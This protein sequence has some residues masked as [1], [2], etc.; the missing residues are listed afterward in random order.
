MF[1][2]KLRSVRGVVAAGLVL[3]LAG[4]TAA[5]DWPNFNGPARDGHAPDTGLTWKWPADG[6]PVAWKRDAGAGFAGVAVSG[7]VAF[8]FNRVGA[9]EVL[10]ALD[11]ATGAEKWKSVART[12]YVDDFGFDDGPRCVPVAAGGRVF[13]LGADG[14]L[15]AVE[16]A[17]GKELWQRN[18]LTAYHA[19]KGY[20][21]AGTGP[22]VVGDRLLVNAG[23]KGAGVVGLDPATGKELWKATDDGPSYS[24]P[25]P[26]TVGGKAC[27]AFFTRAGL[28][29]VDAADGTV[30][31]TK[32]WRARIDASVNAA[33][34]VVRGDEVFLSSSYGTGAILLKL[35]GAEPEE[36]WSGDRSLSCHYNTPVLVGDYLYGIDGRQEGGAARLRCV[37]WKS[38]D[39]KWSV[40]RFGCASL[41]AVDGGLL[42]VTDGGELVR[43][44]ATEKEYQEVS[45]AKLLDAPCRAAPALADGR[46]YVRDEKRLLC[47]RL[48]E[49]K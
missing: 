26:I 42:A 36:V 43:F 7:G 15:R 32:G 44:S 35:K 20:F 38:G 22:I 23:G 18:L 33:S 3:A 11:A 19:R 12:R 30:K 27:A 14:D 4:G 25:T 40:D 29:V 48:K 39:V 45:R 46:L 8:L 5:G 10:V 49:T 28:V 41:I 47:V 34:P 24:S 31:A 6:P 21:G 13:T 9:D 1:A 37:E 2:S 16:A 17:T